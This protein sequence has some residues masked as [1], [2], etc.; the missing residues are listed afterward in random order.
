MLRA[1]NSFPDN[2][3]QACLDLI[4]ATKPQGV[5]AAIDEVC[6]FPKGSDEMLARKL[7]EKFGGSSKQSG[8]GG[9]GGGGGGGGVA[10]GSPPAASSSMVMAAGTPPKPPMHGGAAAAAAAAAAGNGNPYFSVSNKQRVNGEFVVKHY[11]G[12][13][14]YNTAGMCER[15]KDALQPEA[16]ALLDS[17]SSALVRQFSM[18]MVGVMGAAPATPMAAALDGGNGGGG[19]GG[20][21]RPRSASAARRGHRASSV[22]QVSVGS[23]YRSQLAALLSTVSRCAPHYVRCIKSNDRNRPG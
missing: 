17:S 18:C 12:N 13:V 5:L 20:S 3:N 19:G 1:W 10:F 21:R 15:N 2:N 8:T 4:E 7:Y 22:V 14:C 6:M 11:A 16:G 9:G 23:Q